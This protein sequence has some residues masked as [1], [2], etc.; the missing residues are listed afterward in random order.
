MSTND[1][2]FY[3]KKKLSSLPSQVSDQEPI[4]T[5]A[6]NQSDLVCFIESSGCGKFAYL[7]FPEPLAQLLTISEEGQVDTNRFIKACLA[8]EKNG[9]LNF[10]LDDLICQ[11]VGKPEDSPF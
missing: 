6:E 2:K 10:N 4:M 7:N 8:L 5:E 11:L 1:K 3:N 9:Q